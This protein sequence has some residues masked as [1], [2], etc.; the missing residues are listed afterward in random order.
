MTGADPAAAEPQLVLVPHTH[1]DREWYQ[2]FQ[3]FRLRLAEVLDDVIARAEADPAFRFTLDGQAAMVDD[4]L[5]I[6]PGER[7]RLAAQ[8]RRGALAVGPWQ[9]LLDE[10]LCSGETIVRNLELGWRTAE[11][12]GAA[13][14]VGYLPDMFGHAA[15]LPQILARAGIRHA[16]LW[17]GAPGGIEAHAFRW[18]APDGSA[19][20][21]E[22]PWDGY[23]NALDLFAIPDRLEKAAAD[24]RDATR[25]WYGDDPVLGMLGTD[26]S[27]P[28]P[29]LE[30]LSARAGLPMASLWEYVQ[31]FTPD[32]DG[33]LTVEGEL[34]SHARGNILP[35]VI[36]MRVGLKQAM[37][38]AE[39]RL[40]ETEALVAQRSGPAFERYRELAWRR[41]V[42]CTAHDSVTGC[43]VDETA[44]QVAA[45][46]AEAEQMARAV[47]DRLLGDLAAAVPADASLVVNSLPMPRTALAE[48][49][50]PVADEVRAMAVE[51]PDG[52]RVGAQEIGRTPTVLGDETLA[53]ADLELLVR[54]IHGRELY[55]QDIEAYRIGDGE[56]HFDVSRAPRTAEFDFDAFRAELAEAVAAGGSW[57][58]LTRAEP[59]RRVVAAVPVGPSGRVAVRVVEESA[60][61]S[62][63]PGAVVVSGRTMT[64]RVAT[65]E[66]TDAGTLTV[67]AADG[68]T[69]A[70]VGRLISGGDRGD[71][72]NYGPPAR[73][74]VVDAPIDV[75]IETVEA[76]PVRGVMR[77]SRTYEWPVGLA[78]DL[79]E[80]S[81]ATVAV[82]VTTLVE[83]RAGEPFVRVTVSFLNAAADHRL[84]LHVPLPTPASS[85]AAE[86]QFAVTTRG[87]TSE[88]GWGEYP[89]PTFPASSFVS[90]GAATVLLDHVTEYELVDDGAELALTLLR[91]VGKMSR[92]VHPHRDE[93]AGG[94]FDV[95]GGQYL[96]VPVEARLAVLPS[97]G[98]WAGA[99]AVGWAARFRHDALVVGGEAGDSA[100]PAASTGLEV[101]GEGVAVSAIRPVDDGRVEVRMIALSENPT[102]ATV[103]GPIAAAEHTDLLGRPLSPVDVDAG[104]LTVPL[105]PWE[106]TTLRLSLTHSE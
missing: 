29:D 95:P 51:L 3:V 52:T 42:E 9:I 89:L 58:V 49:D 75:E 13:M 40:F 99:D 20:R 73:D 100:L 56:I 5:E 96:G 92:N 74:L 53:A 32:D 22:Y 12:L 34:R 84:R 76:G 11:A 4:Y 37:A 17:R 1:W 14:P 50:G 36:S 71:S 98:G 16:C 30:A 77:V 87:L 79:D 6:R 39:R 23:G 70:D 106:I 46:L 62:A 72:Y 90:A 43:G 54:R 59:R 28:R 60:P 55:G 47:R 64:N 24:Y 57:R 19:V 26:H 63:G 21:V 67:T 15:Q 38:R 102:V 66:V 88:G 97:A 48:L 31:R 103:T 35:G 69:L 44:D 25:S 83:L 82:P 10:F 91:A 33:L 8:V 45:R 41:V 78:D 93:P 81:A 80:R 61:R 86:G 18:E 94:E 85:S 68:T 2:P 105:D 65:V 101:S 104:R 7:D 27:A